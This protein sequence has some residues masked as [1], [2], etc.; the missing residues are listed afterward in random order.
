MAWAI[1]QQE[2]KDPVTQLVLICLA[3]YASADGTSAFPSIARLC[4]DTRLSERAV[5]YQL[6]KLIKSALVR[7][8]N[9]A[10]VAIKIKRLDRRPKVY[11]LI[12]ER[13]AHDAPRKATGCILEQSG[14]HL[15]DERGAPH[16]PNPEEGTVR[17]DPKRVLC[18]QGVDKILGAD[19]AKRFGR[20]P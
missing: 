20:K 3:N 8:G 19:Y 14:V 17:I 2:V 1:E 15:L 9:Q 13:G 18:E 4:R 6:R 11:D 12:M 10:A 5:Q 16:A 7:W